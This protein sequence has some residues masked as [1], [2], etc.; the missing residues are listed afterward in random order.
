MCEALYSEFYK[1]D[2]FLKSIVFV[3]CSVEAVIF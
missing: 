3:A 2:V 1:H